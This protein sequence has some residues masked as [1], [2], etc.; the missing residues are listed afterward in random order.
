MKLC[1]SGLRK[2]EQGVKG[3]KE[4]R[5]RSAATSLLKNQQ[6]LSS[7][8]MLFGVILNA[9]LICQFRLSPASCSHVL[10]AR[11]HWLTCLSPDIPHLSAP[12]CLALSWALPLDRNGHSPFLSLGF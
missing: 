6:G 10:F 1:K 11:A 4:L 2:A 3:S 8:Q 12:G 9:T 7:T 5:R